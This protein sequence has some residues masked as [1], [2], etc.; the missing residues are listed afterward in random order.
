MILK[1]QVALTEILLSQRERHLSVSIFVI[2]D[3]V[4]VEDRWQ[5]G[6]VQL[7]LVA[8]CSSDPQD[9][10]VVR[11]VADRLTFARID[12]VAL[13]S[14]VIQFQGLAVLSLML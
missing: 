1:F 7:S 4:Y 8:V 3:S 14:I 5:H 13:H 12:A 2:I 11:T 6:A 9:T 10:V